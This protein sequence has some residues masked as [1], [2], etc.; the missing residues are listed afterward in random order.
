MRDLS[1]MKDRGWCTTIHSTWDGFGRVTL[2]L[3]FRC[4]LYL[5]KIIGDVQVSMK[6]KL[7]FWF[8]KC[9]IS[10][11]TV[12]IARMH[13]S[14]FWW[15]RWA[16]LLWTLATSLS[17]TKTGSLQ[18]SMALGLEPVMQ[19]IGEL[20][21][22]LV[23]VKNNF[24]LPNVLAVFFTWCIAAESTNKQ[25][26]MWFGNKSCHLPPPPPSPLFLCLSPT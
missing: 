5:W 15:I 23:A 4:I 14:R 9:H 20:L 19:D 11:R 10:D 6:P 2:T 12:R 21:K 24:W 26:F 7:C 25:F 1:V 13:W 17:F 16:H 8:I 18:Y 3:H 22:S